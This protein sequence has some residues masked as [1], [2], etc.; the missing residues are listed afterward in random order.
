MNH[1]TRKRFGQHFLHDQAILQRVE[2][3]IRPKPTDQIVEI[4]PGLGALSRYLIDSAEKIRAI[5]IDR[6]LIEPLER[7]FGEKIS[8]YNSDALTF[9]FCTLA[10]RDKRLRIVGNLPYNIST[11]LLFRLFE[12]QHCIEDM[13]FM[14]QQEVV[15]RLV[16]TPGRKN[17]GRLSIMAQYYCHAE[18]LFHVPPE[19][20]NP[21]PM[22]HSATIRLIPR[23]KPRVE[24]SDLNRFEGVIRQAFSQRRKTI[25][26]TLKKMI[27]KEQ[28]IQLGVDPALR[29]EQLGIEQYA[30]ISNAIQ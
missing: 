23:S 3:A 30:R 6:D 1:R 15:D 8:I 20:F 27:S 13:H 18:S 21:P 4:G 9:D 12:Q 17:Y 14:L 11:P 7:R 28:L 19:A 16:A 5:E 22:V 2:Q 25:R 10:R 29:P 26:N 24:V